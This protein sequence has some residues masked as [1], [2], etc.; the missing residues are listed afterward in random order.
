[1]SDPINLQLLY[2]NWVHSHEED[3]DSEMVFRPSTYK[4]PPAR[5]RNSMDLKQDGSL[6]LGGS[7]ADDRKTLTKSKWSID[8]NT[9][10]LNHTSAN[11]QMMKIK[12]LDGDKLIIE[13]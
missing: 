4:F 3:S 6:I 8:K 9:L 1:M 13:K 12:S 11:A 2:K 5:G 10:I 7:A